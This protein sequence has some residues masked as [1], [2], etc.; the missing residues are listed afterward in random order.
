MS[1][2][3]KELVTSSRRTIIKNKVLEIL[4]DSNICQLPVKLIKI[5]KIYKWEVIPYSKA[6]KEGQVDFSESFSGTYLK[7]ND[8]FFI[9]YNDTHSIERQRWTI[10]HEIGHII[11]NHKL[12]NETSEAEANYFAKQLLIP[13]AVLNYYKANS[14][15]K[16]TELFNVSSEAASYRLK[17]LER[18]YKYKAM[19]GLTS[20][21][22]AFLKQFKI[23]S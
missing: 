7:I 2:T 20:H 4:K 12:S 6:I 11:L 1:E 14:V 19:Y 5:I 18:H 13:L 17:D 10:A 22:K 9:I 23:K 15:N 21:D 3:K 8:T 16:I